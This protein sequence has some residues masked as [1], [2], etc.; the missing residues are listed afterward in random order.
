MTSSEG[1]YEFGEWRLDPAERLLSRNG[2]AVALTPKVFDTLLLLVENAGHLVSKQEFMAR[3]WPDAFVEDVAL[4]QSISHLR[5]TFARFSE[6]GATIETVPK[7]GYRLTSPVQR[8]PGNG[9]GGSSSPAKLT[10]PP[11]WLGA[12]SGTAGPVED[13]HTQRA[14]LYLASRKWRQ[15]L[16][17]VSLLGVL[18]LGAMVGLEVIRKIHEV[19]A[20]GPHEGMPFAGRLADQSR[21]PKITPLISLPGEQG[22]PAF[23]PDGSRVAFVWQSPQ[24]RK[25]GIYAVVVGSQSLLRLTDDARDTCPVWSPDGRYLAF[26]RDSQDQFSILYAS[27]VGRRRAEGLQRISQSLDWS[28]GTISFSGRQAAGVRRVGTGCAYQFDSLDLD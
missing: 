17:W 5:K 26:I 27:R 13:L 16:L 19:R 7:R 14:S 9:Y 6:N 3:V 12:S 10:P 25:S 20:A 22:M 2:Q 8:V 23:S 4:A 21:S 18:A 28:R 11:T 24:T 1:I 15:M